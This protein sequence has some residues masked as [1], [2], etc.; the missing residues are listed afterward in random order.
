MQHCQRQQE[1]PKPV[2][3]C[4]GRSAPGSVHRMRAGNGVFAVFAVTALGAMLLAAPARARARPRAA[5]HDS[6]VIRPA[7]AGFN[8][9]NVQ[10]VR[11]SQVR[12][13]NPGNTPLRI[14]ILTWQGR[15]VQRLRIAPHAQAGWTPARYGVYLYLNAD[16]TDFGSA[17]ITGAHGE[18]V[19]QPLARRQ[20]RTFP[21][22][23]YGIVAVTN[24]SGGGIA[25]SRSHG[26]R[27]GADNGER[28]QPF[29]Q[30]GPWIEVTRRT[31]TFMPWVLVVKAGERINVYNEDA[32]A[33][34]F[35]PGVYPVLYENRRQIRFY[36]RTFGG[37]DLMKNSEHGAIVLHRPGI[38][39]VICFIHSL[40]WKQTYKPLRRYGG[41]PYVMDAV[42][43][44]EPN[45]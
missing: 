16:T 2:H 34:S 25:L 35:F 26:L 5:A 11:G 33:H 20:A 29:M 13:A 27:E 32:M 1:T 17:H 39:H 28:I 45:N 18:R 14:R 22:P 19:L 43:V 36:R 31:M 4:T 9:M 10:L 8:I 44:V 15:A 41:Y 23:A 42:I 6:G 40:P 12:F 24:A 21:A 7:G 30:R 37:F 38:Y 3:T